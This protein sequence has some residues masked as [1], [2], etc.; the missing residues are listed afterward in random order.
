MRKFA[1]MVAGTAAALSLAVAPARAQ[2]VVYWTDFSTAG[3]V[4]PGAMSTLQTFRPFLTATAATSASDFATKVASNTFDLVIYGQQCCLIGGGVYTALSTY[5]AGGGKVLAASWFSG[6]GFDALMGVSQ[7][8]VNGNTVSGSGVMFAGIGGSIGLT[9]PT[10]G[11]YSR[12]YTGAEACL[13]SINSG[14]CA[15]QLGNS[16]RSMMIAP[17]FDTYSTPADG[18]RFV[19]NGADYLLGH[20]SAVP[21]PSTWVLMGTGLMAVMG[22]SR[23]RRQA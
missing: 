10:Y 17:L 19:S 18:E 22:V 11:I 6:D 21:E 12:G 9:N 15:A 7:A 4:L 1:L 20:T 8:S 14:G 3:N 13:A 2:A 5:L 16:G 23:R